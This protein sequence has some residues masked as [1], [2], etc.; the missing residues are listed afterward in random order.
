M[1][2]QIRTAAF[3]WLEKQTQLHGDVLPRDVLEKGFDFKGRRI[4]LPGPKGIWKA[5]NMEFPISICTTTNSPY[6]DALVGGKYLKYSYRGED[7]YH[8]DNVG[9]RK[10]MQQG[11]PLI[12]FLGVVK[13]KYLATWP[14]YIVGDNMQGLSFS[15][16]VDS[17]NIQVQTNVVEDQDLNKEY[18][19]AYMTSNVLIRLHQ[20]SF[21][22]RVL[23]AY[24][25]QCT[26]CSLRHIELLDAAHIICDR[27]DQGE[28]II[29]N[30]I[31]LCKIHHAAFDANILGIN[32]DYQVSVR[33]DILE[34]IDGPML[35]YGIQSMDKQRIILPNRKSDWP[36]KERLEIRFSEFLKAV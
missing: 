10:L 18:R 22:E 28:P 14:V 34:E 13:G 33:Q 11:Q 36:D 8:P 24:Q 23:A 9:L 25:N 35:K 15:I 19:R 21:R 2:D 27:E 5:Q 3:A 20:R 17:N 4:T 6:K 29:Q 1:D 32:P 16:A 12:Y 26:L 30:G 7:P 31:S